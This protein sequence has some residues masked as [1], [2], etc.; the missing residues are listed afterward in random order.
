MFSSLEWMVFKIIHVR[1]TSQIRYGSCGKNS[2]HP[3]V[4]RRDPA[5]LMNQ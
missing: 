1:E 4:L 3:V 5:W 2:T